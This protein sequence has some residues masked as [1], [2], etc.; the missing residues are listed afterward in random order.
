[1]LPAW[2]FSHRVEMAFAPHGA[3][4]QDLGVRVLRDEELKRPVQII[5]RCSVARGKHA[6]M[7]HA[8]WGGDV[9]VTVFLHPLERAELLVEGMKSP[10]SPVTSQA[11]VITT[12]STEDLG[13]PDVPR[14]S[15]GPSSFH[16]QTAGHAAQGPTSPSKISGTFSASSAGSPIACAG[17]SP[18]TG[19]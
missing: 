18:P 8:R 15:P 3:L 12:D 9:A 11:P 17:C 6:L 1:M 19:T 10:R 7:L 4:G 13:P 5:I 2:F 16:S 14:T